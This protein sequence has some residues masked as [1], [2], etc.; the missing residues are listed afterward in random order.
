MLTRLQNALRIYSLYRGL[1]FHVRNAAR[2]AW[3][4]SA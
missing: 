4:A 1:G 2:I 3:R